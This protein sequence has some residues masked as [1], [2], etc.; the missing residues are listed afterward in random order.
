M[1]VLALSAFLVGLMV[2][3]ASAQV[4]PVFDRARLY[5]TEAEFTRAIQPYQQA[6]QAD[7][8]N[9]RAHYWLGV[10]YFEVY[11]Q[12]KS[13][14]APY[15]TGY[16]P[17][18]IASLSEAIKLDPNL[19]GAYGHL[20]DAHMIAGDFDKAEALRKQLQERT[21]RAWYTPGPAIGP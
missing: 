1:R 11:L 4:I 7:A 17:R 13:G 3:M 18:A 12:S 15:A 14:F 5:G 20:I 10:A 19:L 9:A 2:V 6:I 21:R 8:R 16:L